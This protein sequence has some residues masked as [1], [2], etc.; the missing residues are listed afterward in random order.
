LA[1]GRRSRRPPENLRHWGGIPQVLRFCG[2]TDGGAKEISSDRPGETASARRFCA[3]NQYREMTLRPGGGWICGGA[4]NLYEERQEARRARPRVRNRGGLEIS[5]DWPGAPRQ[6]CASSRPGRDQGRPRR[7]AR[8]KL[9]GP[10]R[11]R[12]LATP[13]TSP[14]WAQRRSKDRLN[15]IGAALVIRAGRKL[16][17]CPAGEEEKSFQEALGYGRPDGIFRRFATSRPPS[18]T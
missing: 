1:R 15:I 2:L 5:R 7:A 18:V 10:G 13:G 14:A 17:A 6:H 4:R 11:S 12:F 3:L 8:K 9:S 16:A